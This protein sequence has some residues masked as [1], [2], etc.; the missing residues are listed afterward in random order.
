MIDKNLYFRS[1]ILF[2]KRI[3]NL[4]TIKGDTLIR[5]NLNIS[6]RKTALK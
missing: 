5:N 2:I 6:L 1:I 4:T 3:K